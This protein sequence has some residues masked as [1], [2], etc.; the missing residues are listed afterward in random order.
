MFRLSEKNPQGAKNAPL[1]KHSNPEVAHAQAKILSQKFP[2]T[3]F[4]VMVSQDFYVEPVSE[5]KE[6]NANVD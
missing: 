3:T 6:E 5:Q 1:A 2:G 4:A